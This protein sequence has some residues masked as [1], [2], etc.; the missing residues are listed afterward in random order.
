MKPQAR[1]TPQCGF[2]ILERLRVI[3]VVWAGVSFYPSTYVQLEPERL[4]PPVYNSYYE[5]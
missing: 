3:L 4:G 5:S 1:P 2:A